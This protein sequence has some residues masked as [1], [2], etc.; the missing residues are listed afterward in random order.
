VKELKGIYYFDPIALFCPS[1]NPVKEL[2]DHVFLCLLD[3]L[4][5]RWN[6]VKELKGAGRQVGKSTT[7]A[8]VESGEGIERVI[9]SVLTIR[10]KAVVESGEGIERLSCRVLLQ[11]H[12]H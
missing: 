10:E 3:L 8:V 7:I 6:P 11:S 5:R 2:K 9:E 4:S 1:W 12:Q